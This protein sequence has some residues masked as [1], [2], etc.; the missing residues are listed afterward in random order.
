MENLT[1]VAHIP[2]QLLA[3][4]E[5]T[6]AYEES[7]GRR[8]AD[9]VREFLLAAS[10]DSSP[11]CKRQRPP[12]GGDLA[13]RLCTDRQRRDRT[14]RIHRSTG[15]RRACRNRLQHLARLPGKGLATEAATALV[16]FASSS[17]RVRTVCAYTLPETNASTRVLEKC[18]FRKAWEIFDSENNLVWRWEKTLPRSTSNK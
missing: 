8:I 11:P 16:D 1:L 12:I 17:G 15:F 3:L 6:A 10:P 4:I 7:S 2:R 14:V 18:G 5:S 9:G 13:L